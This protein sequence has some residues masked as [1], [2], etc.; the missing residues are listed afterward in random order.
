MHT[1]THT[2]THMHMRMHMRMHMHM[3]MQPV[4]QVY[5]HAAWTVGACRVHAVWGCHLYLQLEGQ[6][7]HQG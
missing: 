7:E 5:A 3:R 2:H 4:G 1:H 6:G